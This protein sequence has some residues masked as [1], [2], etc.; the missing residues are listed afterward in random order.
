MIPQSEFHAV[1]KAV[2]HS[3]STDDIRENLNAVFFEFLGDECRLVSTDGHRITIAALALPE[4][5]TGNFLAPI[6][7][8]KELLDI[9]KAKSDKRV[10]FVVQGDTFII[11]NGKASLNIE[12]LDAEY[13]DYRQI[14]P[15][16]DTVLGG[17]ARFNLGYL[18]QLATACKSL[19]WRSG[20]VDVITRGPEGIAT[21]RPVLDPSLEVVKSLEVHVM[22]MRA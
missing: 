21:L 14:L 17:T 6:A 4:G 16:D 1:L 3:A 2:I 8:I 5:G 18:A 15:A 7:D 11:T 9:F 20:G 22:P 12:R 10:S 19:M 13:P